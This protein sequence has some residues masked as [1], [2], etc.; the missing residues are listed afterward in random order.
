MQIIAIDHDPLILKK[1]EEY[2]QKA[3]PTACLSLFETAEQALAFIRKTNTV[4]VLFLE[5]YLPGSDGIALAEQIRR[6]HPK[7]NLIFISESNDFMPDA[8]RLHASGY[9]LKPITLPQI[10]D[11]LEVLRFPVKPQSRLRLQCFGTFE[12][13]IHNRPLPF[14]HR[15]TKELLAFLVFRRGAVCTNNE[16]MAAIWEDDTHGSYLRDLRKDLVSTLKQNGCDD[17]IELG[18]GKMALIMEKVDCDYYQWLNGTVNG[19]NAYHGE[20]MSQYS[21]AEFANASM[22]KQL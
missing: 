9:L 17:T 13:F 7:V 5:P 3:A 15:K 8:F 2:L 22:Q 20:F 6:L 10:R 4:D 12:A 21:W 14:R 18:R 16:I 11:Q 19:I 1:L